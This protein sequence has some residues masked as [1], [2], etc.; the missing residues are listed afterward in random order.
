MRCVIGRTVL[1]IVGFLLL[2]AVAVALYLIWPVS[3]PPFLDPQGNRLPHSIAVMESWMING[4]PES[5][6]IRGRDASS[7]V[8]IWVHGGPG[9][10]ETPVVRHFNGALED[11]FLMVYWD[12]RYAGR[13]F[14][15]FGPKPKS[16]RIDDYV[17]D[18]D[19]VIANLRNR[20]HCGKVVLLAHSWGT[21]PGILYAERHPENVAVYVGIGQEADA[22]ESERRSYEWVLSRARSRGDADVVSRL[23]K[24]GPPGP[25]EDYTPRDL[26]QKYGGAFRADLNVPELALM[27]ATAHEVNWRDFAALLFARGYNKEILDA[28][29]KVVLDKDHLQF[30]VPIFFI[31]GRYDHTVYADLSSRYLERLS[32]PK[33]VFVW[34][35]NSAHSP[36]FEEPER[37]NELVLKDVLPLALLAQRSH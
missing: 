34:F 10:S 8:L 9:Q 2:A 37:F 16:L 28:D 6:I 26:I 22:P 12:Q 17:A 24:M 13:S 1:R 29:A 15:P 25:R 3:T 31:S 21:V 35:D 27:S 36:P 7:P 5:V 4:V 20:L 18:L 23:V 19:V 33:K 11:R 32:A 14:D 30:R